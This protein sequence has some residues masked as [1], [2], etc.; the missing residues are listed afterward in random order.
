MKN[1]FTWLKKKIDAKRKFAKKQKGIR[2]KSYHLVS[3]EEEKKH[4][5]NNYPEKITNYKD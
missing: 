3:E 5:E 2:I 4:L 1:L